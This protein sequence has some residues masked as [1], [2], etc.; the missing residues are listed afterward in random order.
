MTIRAVR[1]LPREGSEH[2]EMLP[3]PKAPGEFH[4]ATMGYDKCHPADIPPGVQGRFSFGCPRGTGRC[5]DIIIGNGFKPG[6][7]APTWNWDGN[8]DAPTL[9]P[10]INCRTHTD[11]GEEAAGCGWHGHLTGGVFKPA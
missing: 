9:T 2:A 3:T 4:F 7:G 1:L 6:A 10:S 11:S 5:G 8:P